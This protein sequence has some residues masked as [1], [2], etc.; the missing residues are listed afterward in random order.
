[1]RS[2]FDDTGGYRAEFP[3]PYPL[4]AKFTPLRVACG[5]PER[6]AG[7]LDKRLNLLK[8]NSMK[9]IALIFVCVINGVKFCF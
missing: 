5:D 6:G 2:D 3:C 1:M 4:P 7:E 9:H 8:N